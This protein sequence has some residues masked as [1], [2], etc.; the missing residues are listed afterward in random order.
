MTILHLEEVETGTRH[1]VTGSPCVIGRHAEADLRLND[2]SVARRHARLTH[3]GGHWCVEDL[4]SH[5]G[6]WVNERTVHEPRPLREGDVLQ[7]AGV[8]LVV[9]ID[10]GGA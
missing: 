4:Q 10:G 6:I 9:R 5:C 1:A 3:A 7:V 2:K 8:K